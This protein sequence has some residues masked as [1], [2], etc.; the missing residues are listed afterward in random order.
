MPNDNAPR[1]RPAARVL[2]I[3]ELDRVLLLRAGV[4]E[5]G[6]WI[7]PGGALEPG[8]TAEQAALRELR[9]ETGI[10]DAALIPV[11]IAAKVRTVFARRFARGRELPRNLSANPFSASC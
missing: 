4:G 8:E 6:V 2:L 5:G 10:E 3:D 11:V 9:E 1:L 7:T